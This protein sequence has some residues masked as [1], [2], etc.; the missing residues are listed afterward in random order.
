MQNNEL[1]TIAATMQEALHRAYALGRSD[2]LR[3]VVEIVQSDELGSK[4]VALLSHSEPSVVEASHAEAIAP[5]GDVPHDDPMHKEA[6]HNEAMHKD[7]THS[8]GAHSDG[9]HNDNAEVGTPMQEHSKP[10]VSVK[11]FLLDYLYPLGAK[12]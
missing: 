4:T 8:D 7:A 10:P 9:A 6:T 2:A 11:D 1:E 12:K 5:T 3:R